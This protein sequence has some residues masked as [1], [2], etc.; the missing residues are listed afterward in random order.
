VLAKKTVHRAGERWQFMGLSHPP[1][2]ASPIG[3]ASEMTM[4]AEPPRRTNRSGGPQP[5]RLLVTLIISGFQGGLQAGP[6][7]PPVRERQWGGLAVLAPLTGI[8]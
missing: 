2:T 6:G 1:P 5:E 7:A 3:A 8:G 4:M